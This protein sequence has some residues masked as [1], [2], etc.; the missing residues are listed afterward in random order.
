[1][2]SSHN[3]CRVLLSAFIL[4][5][6]ITLTLAL[7]LQSDNNALVPREPEALSTWS[8]G[9]PKLELL[10]QAKCTG[11]RDQVRACTKDCDRDAIICFGECMCEVSRL[12]RMCREEC[13][14]YW[15]VYV[16]D[17]DGGSQSGISGGT[18]GFRDLL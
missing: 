2:H 1:M 8:A 16:W 15:V 18:P 13:F 17:G 14:E 7:P 3:T 11:C 9:Y 5:P 12:E 4:S 10:T 6:L